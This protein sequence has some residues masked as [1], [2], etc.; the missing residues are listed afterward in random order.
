MLPYEDHYLFLVALYVNL[1]RVLEDDS[2][3]LAPDSTR[4]LVHSR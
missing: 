1:F 4:I 3:C 2:Q